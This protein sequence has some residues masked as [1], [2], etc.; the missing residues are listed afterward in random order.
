M[1]SGRTRTH[2]QNIRVIRPDDFLFIR[3]NMPEKPLLLLHS[4]C[5]DFNFL[6]TRVHIFKTVAKCIFAGKHPRL[7]L[8]RLRR[9]PPLLLIFLR[10][11]G[12][13][14]PRQTRPSLAL[15]AVLK[16]LPLR[17]QVSAEPRGPI[18]EAVFPGRPGNILS[19]PGNQSGFT[20]VSNVSAERKRRPPVF[21]G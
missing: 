15:I 14:T 19:F 6:L 9:S 8:V 13:A 18:S 16:M 17:R 10:R 2:D 7:T 1:E 21:R 5:P 11:T 4:L 3:H 20:A 12:L